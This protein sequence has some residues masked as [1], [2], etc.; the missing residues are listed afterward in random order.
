MDYLI[1]KIKNKNDKS[2]YY[3]SLRY[4]FIVYHFKNFIEEKYCK[5]WIEWIKK[6]IYFP[7]KNYIK[8]FGKQ[9]LT[10]RLQTAFGDEGTSYKFSG[11]I[12]EAKP[13]KKELLI[14][15]KVAEDLSGFKLNFCLINYYRNGKDYIG[16]HS[17][18]EKD[19]DKTAPIVSI[20]FG[21]DRLFEFKSND[22][23]MHDKFNK[24]FTI[25]NGDVVV[26]EALTNEYYKHSV[27]KQI[28]INKPRW[29]FTFRKIIVQKK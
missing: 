14:L 6:N 1:N 24:K 9:V 11:T 25:S 28:H 15:K 29:N 19:L 13:W 27:L 22:S 12:V 17:D 26:F 5:I 7:K 21:V 23:K 4:K 8:L 3:V 20:T 18:D 16:F 10:P 2:T